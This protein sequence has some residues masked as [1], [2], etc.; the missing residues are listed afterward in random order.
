MP[1]VT[2]RYLCIT[3]EEQLLKNEMAKLE[4]KQKEEMANMALDQDKMA[5]LKAK[6][7]GEMARAQARLQ[8]LQREQEAAR[9]VARVAAL[10]A[11]AEDTS[12]ACNLERL[13]VANPHDHVQAYV[14]NQSML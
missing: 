10:Q 6:Q 9:N 7:K 12:F 14:D 4:T 11:E 2:L 1:L 5:K 13:E 8:L 3:R